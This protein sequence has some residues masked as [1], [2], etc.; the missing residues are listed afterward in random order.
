MKIKRIFFLSLI[1]LL[2]VGGCVC[3]QVGTELTFLDDGVRWVIHNKHWDQKE[4]KD[5][6][7]TIYNRFKEDFTSVEVNYCYKNEK[8]SKAII[9]ARNPKEEK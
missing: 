8:I 2:F 9:V 6:I 7:D 3:Y 5:L 1:C 4:F